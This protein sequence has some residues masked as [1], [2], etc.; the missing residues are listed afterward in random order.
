MCDM[1]QVG[2]RVHLVRPDQDSTVANWCAGQVEVGTE[3]TVTE[4]G[5]E[6]AYIEW[7]RIERRPNATIFRTAIMADMAKGSGQFVRVKP[8]EG[9]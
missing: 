6:I 3:G 7:D 4:L 8:T 1:L 2:D 5:P 9:E